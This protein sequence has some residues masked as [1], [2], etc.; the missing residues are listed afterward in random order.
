MASDYIYMKD[1]FPIIDQVAV[2]N[3]AQPV[4]G[5]KKTDGTE[6]TMAEIANRNSLIALHNEGIRE[7]TLMLKDR[8]IKGE[9]P[10]DA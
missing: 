9:D 3:M 4:F 10:D 8:L 5:G 6:M 2:E 7:M 1:L